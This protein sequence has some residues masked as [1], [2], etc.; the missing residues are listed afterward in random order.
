MSKKA[1]DLSR[2]KARE[3]V[4]NNIQLP[5]QLEDHDSKLQDEIWDLVNKWCEMQYT[6]VPDWNRRYLMDMIWDWYKKR[7]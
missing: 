2:K 5:K 6:A 1:A 4:K 3:K 7:R